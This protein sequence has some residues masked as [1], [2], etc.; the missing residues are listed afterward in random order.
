MPCSDSKSEKYTWLNF[1]FVCIFQFL[2]VSCSEQ[3]SIKTY[4]I[5]SEYKGPVVSWKLPENWGENPDLSGPMAG[6]FH[7]VTKTGQKGRIGVMP[8]RENVSTVDVAN[9]FSREMGLP[10]FDEDSIKSVI[11]EKN[12]GD[13]TFEWLRLQELGT[14]SPQTRTALLALLRQEGETWLFPLLLINK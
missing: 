6:S 13:R 5:P 1:L 12:I 9:M 10:S 8:F 2:S 7:I 3:P 14:T 11:T 4:T